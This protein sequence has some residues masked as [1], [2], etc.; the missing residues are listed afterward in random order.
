MSWTE[1]IVERLLK[2][3]DAIT[4]YDVTSVRI[5]KSKSDPYGVHYVISFVDPDDVF[6]VR[7][8]CTCEGFRY[9][10]KCWHVTDAKAF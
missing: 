5:Y 2:A 4:L 8:I 9:N 3:D 10:D 1:E 7:Y 6:E